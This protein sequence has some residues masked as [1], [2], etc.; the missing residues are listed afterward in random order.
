MF[1]KAITCSSTVKNKQ[2][3][4][5][6]LNIQR[7]LDWL[8]WGHRLLFPV[9]VKAMSKTDLRPSPQPRLDYNPVSSHTETAEPPRWPASPVL[10]EDWRRQ[11]LCSLH[12]FILTLVGRGPLSTIRQVILS[13]AITASKEARR[14]GKRVFWTRR[15]G[16]GG[17]TQEERGHGEGA[18]GSLP[19]SLCT[20]ALPREEK[21]GN[22]T[23][24]PRKVWLTVSLSLPHCS[25][26]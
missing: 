9:W 11:V 15:G 2:R 23:A 16:N 3:R 24:T 10:G 20:D 12:D 1:I 5:G 6:V 18:L 7:E 25:S 22:C 4:G 17:R 19:R 26:W 14:Q 21:P 8:L 13:L